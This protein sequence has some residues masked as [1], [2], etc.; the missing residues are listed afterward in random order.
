MTP[1]ATYALARPEW[2]CQGLRLPAWRPVCKRGN[3]SKY[4]QP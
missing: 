3:L 2:M 1:L 4:W